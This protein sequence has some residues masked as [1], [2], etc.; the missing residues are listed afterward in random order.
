ML[1]LVGCVAV[2]FAPACAVV[3]PEVVA[4]YRFNGGS[5]GEPIGVPAN[6][7]SDP[8]VVASVVTSDGGQA[9]TV[10]SR[11]GH[12]RAVDFPDATD[13]AAGRRSVLSITDVDTSDGDA[14]SPGRRSFTLRADFNLDAGDTQADGGNNLVQRGL[15]T[16]T[17]QFKVQ[18]DLGGGQAWPACAVGQTR[19]REWQ[20]AVATSPRPVQ[21]GQWYRV[22]CRRT[23]H[24]LA[25]TVFAIVD[26][27]TLARF[28]RIRV[29][30]IHR[31]NLWWPPDSTVPMTIGGK[32]RPNGRFHPQSDQFNGVVDNVSLRVRETT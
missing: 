26:D 22:R 21:P 10:R 31:F 15:A 29:S 16:S 5:I 25:L 6:L 4:E 20:V 12:G 19:D 9:V 24:A 7:G 14:L 11:A 1:P 23:A 13:S 3:A 32:L 18:V 2:I 27:G 17:D 8:D 30:G 28:S